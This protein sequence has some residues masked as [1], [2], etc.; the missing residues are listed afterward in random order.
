M[1]I[2]IEQRKDLFDLSTDLA[3]LISY[4]KA[5]LNSNP[6]LWVLIHKNPET[7]NYG[8]EV[9]NSV[10]ST[11]STQEIEEVREVLRICR[12]P[13]TVQVPNIVIKKAR[14]KKEL[15]HEI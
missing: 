5:I 15:Y 4:R 11:C 12:N 6:R 14:K 2:P 7:K 1:P 8:L 13:V 9:I 3:L 10:G